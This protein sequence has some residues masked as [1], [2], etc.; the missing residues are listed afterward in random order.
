MTDS[1]SAPP[2]RISPG[3]LRAFRLLTG[4]VAVLGGLFIAEA[5]LRWQRNRIERSDSLEPGLVQYDA[6]LGWALKPGWSGRH[7]HHDY[8]ATYSIGAR[9]LRN[10]TPGQ[11][12]SGADRVTMVVGDSFTF[13]LGV[14]D[15]ATFVHHLQASRPSGI[16]F[17]N[18]AVPGYSNDQ[19]ALLIEK[20]IPVIKPDRIV[21]V[22]YLGNDLFDNLLAF[23][24]Q[25]SSPKPYFIKTTGGL[26][27]RN[28][29]VPQERKPRG[30]G[31]L[32]TA[33]WGAEPAGWPW[34]LR[35]EQKSEL[36]R[37]ISPK[38]LPQKKHREDMASRFAPALQLFDTLLQRIADECARNKVR[39]TVVT[40]AGRSFVDSPGSVSAQYQ[41][42][43]REQVLASS[44]NR[45]LAVVDLAGLM[46]ERYRREKGK[47]YYPNEGH[48]NATGHRVVAEIL[49]G[50]LA[51]PGH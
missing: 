28:S 7:T 11:P 32:V 49:Q 46:Q 35:L 43:F 23:P 8:T 13:G 30:Y 36:F 2:A 40:L 20:Q 38:V 12:G 31:N 18:S 47:W 17:L 39:L 37:V 3:K 9:G 16:S 51:R 45:Q 42:V 22:V 4:L 5:G 50:E 24:L 25:V 19:E 33:V 29:P 21:L 14:N 26:V 48:L 44:R 41:D 1:L 10:D 27:L 15:D 6:E 34:W